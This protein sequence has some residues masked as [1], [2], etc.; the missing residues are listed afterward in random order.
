MAERVETREETY[1]ERARRVMPSGVS[2]NLRAT[3]RRD[4]PIYARGR[5]AVIEDVDGRPYLDYLCGWGSIILGHADAAVTAA[6]TRALAGGVTFGATHPLEIEAAERV[7]AALP[8]ADSVRF[9]SSGSE[10]VHAA[11]RIARAATGRWKIARFEGHYHGWLDTIYIGDQP[12]RERPSAPAAPGTRG[13]P[14]AAL[15]DVVVLPWNE[16]DALRAALAVHRGQLAA[17]ILEPILCNTGVIP[18]APGV[19]ETLREWCDREGTVLIFDEVIT[20]FRTALG[21]AQ[22]LLGVTPDL[23]T[24]GKAVANGFP[25]SGVAGRRVLMEQLAGDVLHGGTYNGN[26]GSMAATCATLDV[27]AGDGGVYDRLRRAG[28]LLMDGL[29]GAGAAAGVPVL[30]QGPGPVF[31]LWIT[32]KPS[33]T[34]PRTAKTEGAAAYA[35]FVEAITRRGVRPVPGGRWYLTTAHTDEQIG[36]TVRAAEAAFSEIRAAVG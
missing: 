4:L 20:G 25:L 8:C 24:F 10:A 13:Q 27:L 6:V 31:H 16:P 29:R 7:A 33:I 22:S 18:A 15:H 3:E 17:I 19:L 5:G 9:C 2:S 1:R 30:T 32:D 21:G 35:R 14:Q 28:R 11:L 12:A 34:D 23:A 36:E 26:V